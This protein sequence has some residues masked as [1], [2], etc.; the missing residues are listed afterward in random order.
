MDERADAPSPQYNI[1]AGEKG[2]DVLD[3]EEM[4]DIQGVDYVLWD[5]SVSPVGIGAHA[6]ISRDQAADNYS[7]TVP[8]AYDETLC[9]DNNFKFVCIDELKIKTA[10]ENGLWKCEGDPISILK[11]PNTVIVSEYMNNSQELDFEVGDKII[12]AMFSEEVGVMDSSRNDKKYILSQ[13]LNAYKY[14]YVELT[15]GR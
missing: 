2:F 8:A 13:Q 7:N 11:N 12:I 5:N 6:V 9:A 3:M 10:V 14:A 4:S 15:V 1:S